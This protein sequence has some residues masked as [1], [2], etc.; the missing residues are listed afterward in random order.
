MKLRQH[1]FPKQLDTIQHAFVLWSAREAEAHHDIIDV[2]LL[3][4]HG[5]LLDTFL[6]RTSYCMTKAILNGEIGFGTKVGMMGKNPVAVIEEQFLGVNIT[7]GT[8]CLGAGWG[9]PSI[10]HQH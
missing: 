8:L 4:I 10:T 7:K 5:Q 2:I 3:L 6:W 9:H 1:L